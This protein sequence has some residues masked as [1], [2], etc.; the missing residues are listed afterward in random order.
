MLRHR[1]K[2][3]TSFLLFQHLVKVNVHIPVYLTATSFALIPI[4]E[5]IILALAMAMDLLFFAPLNK[6]ATPSLILLVGF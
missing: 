2:N 4:S 3:L 1:S 6:N 5:L